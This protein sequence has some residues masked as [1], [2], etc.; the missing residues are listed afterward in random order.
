M[1]LA[2]KGTG[3]SYLYENISPRVRVA[4][5][6]V[7]PAKLFV[8]NA[9]GTP[10]YLSRYKVVVLDEVQTLKFTAPEEIIA[11]LKMFLAN[12]QIQRGTTPVGSDC[13]FVMLA[14]IALDEQQRPIHELLVRDLPPFMQET[15]FLDRLCGLLPGWRIRKLTGECFASGWGLKADFFGDTL[16]MLR[17]D[18]E[19]ESEA[20]SRLRFS[21]HSYGRNEKGIRANMNALFKLLFPHGE[22]SD[23]EFYRCCLAPAIRLRQGIWDQLYFMDAENHKYARDLRETV[24]WDTPATG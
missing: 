24:I 23:D 12:A 18:G 13:G 9:K 6:N 5:G 19:L 11:N 3:K 17:E 15:A 16:L 21:P 1:E 14:N 10:G 20:D 4:G 7:T 2:P 22:A 8:D